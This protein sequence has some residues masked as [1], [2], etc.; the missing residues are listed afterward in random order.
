MAKKKTKKVIRD[1]NVNMTEDDTASIE[2]G[3]IVDYITGKP[4]KESAKEKVRQRIARAVFHEYG[5]SPDD[6][7]PDF[8]VKVGSRRKGVDIAIFKTGSEHDVENL[9]R[10]VICKPEPKK[11]KKGSFKLR[12][13]KQATKDLDELKD[14]MEAIDACQWGLWTNGMEFFFLKK[15]QGRFEASFQPAGD[16]PLADDS[17][18][19]KDV[20]SHAKLRKA[21]PELLRITFRR[22]HN[23]IH[24][25]EGMSKD[26]AFWQFLY[27]IFAKM[28]DER[29]TNGDRRFWV[30][31]DERFTEKGQAAIRK[32]IIPLFEATRD[33]YAG[34]KYGNIFRGNEEIQLSDRALAFMVSE[35]AKYDFGRTDT[36]AKGAAYQ[37]IVGDTL[38]GDRGQFFTPSNA[39]KLMVEMLAPK[40]TERVIDPACGTGG[41]LRATLGYLINKYRQEEGTDADTESTTTFVNYQKRL[42]DFAKKYLFGADFDPSLVRAS[43]M[44]VVMACNQ[45]AN[46]FHMNSLE[47]RDG[48]LSGVRYMKKK[49]DL[50]TMDVVM[51]NPPFGSDIPVTDPNILRKYELAHRWERT[52]SGGFR[53]TESRQG[54]VAPEILFIERCLQ[55]LKPGGRMGIVLPDGI[56]GNPGDEY[57]RWW[58][59][60]HAYVLASVDLPVECFIVEANVNI[61]TS[62]LFLKKKT[63]EEIAAEDVSGTKDYPVFMAVAEKVGYDRRGNTLYKRSPDGEEILEEVEKEE[64]VRLAGEWVTRKLTRKQRVLDDDMPVIAVEY[65]KFRDKYPVPGA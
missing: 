61:L 12:D 15:E 21:D 11:G 13:H 33:E 1:S 28:Y 34:D 14:L 65:R 47:F 32:R 29:Q 53:K 54:S 42:K 50:G 46:I 48:T 24:G 62:L 3:K 51:T 19:T 35:L 20:H 39:V 37:E 30:A 6:M 23:F 22:C 56:L 38:R 4:V 27:L 64:K 45:M 63:D 26:V 40:D 44:N 18:G 25:N 2:D 59:M 36:D 57:I 43:Q 16:W 49:G 55:W 31:P 60:R 7:E 58:I 8:K 41:F 52:E 9:H 10:V 5:F 17:Q